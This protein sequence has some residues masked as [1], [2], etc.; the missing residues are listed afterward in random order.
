LKRHLWW[1]TST[2]KSQQPK[3]HTAKAIPAP[4][5]GTKGVLVPFDTFITILL[6]PFHFHCMGKG[7]KSTFSTPLEQSQLSIPRF[8]LEQS[9]SRYTPNSPM[10]FNTRQHP[11]LNITCGLAGTGG[12]VRLI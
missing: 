1:E 5:K 3:W 7:T 12:I 4:Q 6:V 10:E 9:Q 8:W 11:L 2:F